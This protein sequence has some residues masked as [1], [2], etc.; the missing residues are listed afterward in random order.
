MGARLSTIRA[1]LDR[2]PI[3]SIGLALMREATGRERPLEAIAPVRPAGLAPT[4]RLGFWSLAAGVGASTTAALVAQ[5]SAAAGQ[6][7]LLIDLDRW[8]PS[9]AL[10]ASVDAATITDVLIQP[11]R[12]RD[13]VSRWGDVAFLA[14]SSEL[15]RDFDGARVAGA[16]ERLSA[17]RPMVI[18]LGAGADALDPAIVGRLTR[19]VVV[20]GAR[21][22]QLQAVFCARPLLQ[23]VGCP[24]GLALIA[25]ADDDAALIAGRAQ[26]PLLGVVPPDPFLARDEFAARA[27][28]MRAID[29]LI[30]SL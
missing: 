16:L 21:V 2:T 13:L 30:R 7:P 23:G 1:W 8:V 12:E 11:D 5:R 17:G 6:A 15:H 14:G 18:D 27:T 9:L 25:L 24:V 22:G 29:A 10:R 20:A 26:M 4:A 19:L 28:T 3:A